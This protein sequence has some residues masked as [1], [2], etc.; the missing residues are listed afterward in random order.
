MNHV[1]DQQPG[2]DEAWEWAQR[3]SARLT[4][5]HALRLYE[6]ARAAPGQ[7]VEVGSFKGG[8]AVV[9]AAASQRVLCID[10]FQYSN[11]DGR[12][13]L[14]SFL[15]NVGACPWGRRVS[16]ITRPDYEVFAAVPDA[17]VTFLFID[18]DHTE[19]STVRSLQ[20][21]MK[22]LAPSARIAVHDY[23]H[24]RYPGVKRALDDSQFV[25][26]ENCDGLAVC[27]QPSGATGASCFT[28]F[29]Q[30][31]FRGNVRGQDG[32]E[33]ATCRL[34]QEFVGVSDI[35][36]SRVGRDSCVACSH[37]PIAD[38]AHLNT[39][40]ASHVFNVTDRIIR[41]GGAHGCSV[42]EAAQKQQDVEALVALHHPGADQAAAVPRATEA[43]CFLADEIGSKR[44]ETASGVIE[45][46]VFE[47]RHPDHAHTTAAECRL[48]RDW[49]MAVERPFH[50]PASLGPLER[51]LSEHRG[52]AVRRWAVGV[53]TAPRRQPTLELCLD[54]MRRAGWSDIRLFVDTPVE[55]PESYEHLPVT[56]RDTRV[57][58]WPNYYLAL[59]QLC[60]ESAD[61]D[62]I[63][64]AQDDSLFYDQE[65][66]CA[67]LED[68]LWLTDPPGV[69][70]LFCSAVDAKERPGWYTHQGAWTRGAHA[71]VFPRNLARQFLTDRDVVAHRQRGSEGLVGIDTVIGQW[72]SRRGIP[73]VFP[74]PS[75]VQHI[76]DT[77]TLWK[78]ARAIGTRRA[79][80]TRL[81]S[82]R[83][84]DSSTRYVQPGDG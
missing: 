79:F 53:T 23:G 46:T 58:A 1:A 50:E 69:V 12:D 18:N 15:R 27:A 16:L 33:S 78:H 83:Q 17:S 81:N 52:G 66:L 41:E 42:D 8:S 39:V 36:Y 11:R 75:L 84:L 31:E 9:L 34:V 5:T 7:V 54:S 72:A 67:Y 38:A 73:V 22:T 56:L 29:D 64:I 62:A 48:C 24:P 40:V 19:Q 26:L 43:C 74:S 14:H 60:A 3:S 4:R 77:S 28:P 61:A 59:A 82:L 10:P 65:N 35:E 20:G 37:E 49:S 68:I 80:D 47:C 55:L 6:L 32:R 76:G 71:F 51:A 2:F 13:I 70:S 44:T 30:C 25:L 45:E 63:L 57:G 21:W